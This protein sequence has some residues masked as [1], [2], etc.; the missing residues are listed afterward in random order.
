MGSVINLQQK[1]PGWALERLNRVTGLSFSRLPQSLLN[2]QQ[3]D[4]EKA[5]WQ[6]RVGAALLVDIQQNIDESHEGSWVSGL[7]R[8]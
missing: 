6:E 8:P 3:E 2:F 4:C 7:A 1:A 5:G